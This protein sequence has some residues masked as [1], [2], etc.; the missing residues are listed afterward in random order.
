ML[1]FIQNLQLLIT[2]N[3]KLPCTSLDEFNQNIGKAIQK[4]NQSHIMS[5]GELIQFAVF[6]H[7]N[8][9]YLQSEG[10]LT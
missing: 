4:F 2:G 10:E 1:S 6:E 9:D 5:V 3:D 7:L 8:K